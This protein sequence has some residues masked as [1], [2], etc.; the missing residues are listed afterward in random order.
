MVI[1]LSTT[2]AYQPEAFQL[3]E[4]KT[5]KV[6]K[7]ITTEIF[8]AKLHNDQRDPGDMSVV[9]RRRSCWG[10]LCEEFLRSGLPVESVCSHGRP[11]S[12]L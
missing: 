11:T 9:R 10:G 1:S 2:H 6:D 3:R 7:C 8:P 5:K 12:S 4:R